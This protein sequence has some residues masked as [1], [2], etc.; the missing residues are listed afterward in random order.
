MGQWGKAKCLW[1]NPSSCQLPF[2]S[3]SPIIY[4]CQNVVELVIAW[5]GKSMGKNSNWAETHFWKTC[6]DFLGKENAQKRMP[7][8]HASTF[9]IFPHHSPSR[10]G[11]WEQLE[12][13]LCYSFHVFGGWLHFSHGWEVVFVV[14]GIGLFSSRFG[15]CWCI[16][17]SRFCSFMCFYHGCEGPFT[18]FTVSPT[19]GLTHRLFGVFL[20]VVSRAHW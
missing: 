3:F 10:W 5:N 18:F 4:F 15:S 17:H 12:F 6:S 19:I 13:F 2:F 14:L 11:F 8:C 7:F 16:F 1:E 9:S 20:P